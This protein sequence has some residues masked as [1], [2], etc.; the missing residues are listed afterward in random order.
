MCF[1]LDVDGIASAADIGLASSKRSYG[2]LSRLG[3]TRDNSSK[4]CCNSS[5]NKLRLLP[6]AMHFSKNSQRII[7]SGA[8]A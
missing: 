5:C 2:R 4:Q 3:S 8:A 6:S 1:E 7:R